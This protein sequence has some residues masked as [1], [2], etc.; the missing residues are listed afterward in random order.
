MSD[1]IMLTSYFHK[2]GTERHSVDLSEYVK[3]QQELS[4]IK[5]K[6]EAYD[7]LNFTPIFETVISQKDVINDLRLKLEKAEA[8]LE[9]CSLDNVSPRESQFTAREALKEIRG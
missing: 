4:T 5:A 3:L 1:E 2:D 6:L 8:A 9:F 7:K